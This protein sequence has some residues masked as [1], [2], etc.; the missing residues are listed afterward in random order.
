MSNK[1]DAAVDFLIQKL[2]DNIDKFTVMNDTDG[3]IV[4]PMPKGQQITV[5]CKSNDEEGFV[6]NTNTTDIGMNAFIAKN[7]ILHE[8]LEKLLGE[9]V[10]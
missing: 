9:P 1:D 4:N 2:Y 7:W 3:R 8:E 10:K 5:F 6:I